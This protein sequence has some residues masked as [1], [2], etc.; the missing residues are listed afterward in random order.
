MKQDMMVA[1]MYMEEQKKMTP[2]FIHVGGLI[3]L[4]KHETQ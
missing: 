4:H 1:K 2:C 3:G